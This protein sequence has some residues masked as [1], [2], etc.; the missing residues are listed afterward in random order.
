[1]AGGCSLFQHK[2]RITVLLLGLRV[3]PQTLAALRSQKAVLGRGL[4][5]VVNWVVM[6]PPGSFGS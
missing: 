3:R 2:E 5:V 6:G 4:F 1:M